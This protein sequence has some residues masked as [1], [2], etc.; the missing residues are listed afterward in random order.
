MKGKYLI[1]TDSWFLVPD[2][3]QYRSVWGEI[4]IIEDSFLGLK[5]NRNSTNWFAKIGTDNKCVIVAG[6]QIHYA[7]KCKNKPEMGEVSDYAIND[8]G[9][10]KYVRPTQIWIAE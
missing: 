9:M 6:C 2:G 4:E 3:K 8:S 7:I 10:T 5:T 1:T